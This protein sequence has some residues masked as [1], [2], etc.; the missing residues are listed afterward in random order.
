[1]E[2]LFNQLNMVSETQRQAY[3]AGYS[4]GYKAKEKELEDK[5]EREMDEMA[6]DDL[7]AEELENEKFDYHPRPEEVR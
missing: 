3:R 7:R 6:R 2:D 4:A 1:M 5:R